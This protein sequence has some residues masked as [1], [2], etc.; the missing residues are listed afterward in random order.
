MGNAQSDI[1]QSTF[2]TRV[3]EGSAGAGRSES[4]IG[5]G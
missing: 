3:R 5:T 1:E 4:I 2:F